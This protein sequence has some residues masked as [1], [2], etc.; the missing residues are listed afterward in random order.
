MT[1]CKILRIFVE[2][3]G[4]Y[5]FVVFPRR[6]LKFLY[7]LMSVLFSLW[8]AQIHDDRREYFLD[9]KGFDELWGQLSVDRIF[10]DSVCVRFQ[11]VSS[12]RGFQARR[13]RS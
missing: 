12:M 11:T 9:R 3:I 8:T 4:R 5:L 2:L 10:L 13:R 6:G 7:M 1:V